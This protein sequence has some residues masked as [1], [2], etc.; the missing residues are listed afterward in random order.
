MPL[1]GYVETHGDILFVDDDDDLRS[2]L[3]DFVETVFGRHILVAADLEGVR[4][5][6]A[7]G[8]DSALAIIDVNLGPYKPNGFDVISWLKDNGFKGRAVILTGHVRSG[9]YGIQAQEFTDVPILS[10][11]L[12]ADAL[13]SLVESTP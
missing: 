7:R 9:A 12:A 13:L 3:A 5:L 2:A 4:A 8:I 6:G 10:K 1:S 11:P